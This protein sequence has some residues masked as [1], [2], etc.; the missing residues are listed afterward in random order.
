M[1]Q[2]DQKL[3]KLRVSRLRL[4]ILQIPVLNNE[5]L[6]NSDV[7][8]IISERRGGKLRIKLSDEKPREGGL[9][10]ILKFSIVFIAYLAYIGLH[11]PVSL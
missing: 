10:P 3:S 9:W 11:W 5:T 1:G 8:I 2:P 7:Q 4:H 6:F